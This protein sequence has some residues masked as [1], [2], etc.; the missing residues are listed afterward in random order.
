MS[1]STAILTDIAKMFQ[2]LN[3]DVKAMRKSLDSIDS[4]NVRRVGDGLETVSKQSKKA[5]S[6]IKGFA[7]KC[8]KM[9]GALSAIAAVQLGS[10]FT[11]MAGGILNMG[12]A[13]VQAAAQMRQYEIAFQTMLKSA[14]AGTQMLRDLQQ[15]AAETPF[16]VPGVVSAGQQLMAFGFKAEEIIPMLTNLGDAASGL[17]LGTEGV[18]RLAYALGQMQTSGKLNA[19]DMMQLTSAG[20][21][22]WDMLAQAAGK[23]V[24]EMKDLCSKGAIDSKAAVQTIVAGMNEQFGGMMAKTSDEV[25]GLLANIEETAGNTSAA[26]GKYLT[27]AFNIKGILK[28][29]SDRLGEF[30]QKMQTATE[31]GKSMGDVIKECVPAPVIAVIGAFAAVLVVVSVAAVATLGAVL[32][33]SAGIVAAGAAIGA[34]IALIITYWDDLANAVKAAVQGILDTVVIIGTAVTEVILGVVRWILDTIGD[35]WADITGDHNN[36]FNDFA[37]MLGDAMDA[38]EDFARK[39]IEWFNK[40]FAAKQRATA[41]ESSADDGHGG[42]G[43]SYGDDSSAEKPKKRPV[44]PKRPLII[45]SR[46]T[47]V[48]RTSGSRENLALKAL[49]DENRINQERRKI[50]NEYVRLKL[51]KEKDLFEAQNAIAKKYGTDAQKYQIQL[52][53]IEFNKKQELQEEE[54]AY[55][56][57]ML[58]AENALKEAQLRGASQKELEMLREKLALLNK[59]HQYTIDNINQTAAANANSAQTD[60]YNKEAEWQARHDTSST[61][62]KWSMDA[63]RD[64]ETGKAKAD[65]ATT[66]EEK[67]RLMNEALQKYDEEQQKINTISKIQQTSNQLAKDFSGAITDWITGA[68]SFGDAMKSILKQLIAQLIQAA[69]YATIVAACTGGGGG[70]AARWSK[71]FGKGLATGGS[72]DGPGTGTS[73]SVPAMLSNGE[74]VLNAQAVDRLGVP[75]L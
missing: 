61:V 52:K 69:I 17:G 3:S 16:D 43:G 50:E 36:W 48:G 34:A 47:N 15:F 26:V 31:Q 25:A 72:V 18:S 29:V 62:D 33:L 73:D 71:A 54:L 67:V 57:Q 22:A 35:M 6:G 63:E 44:I 56:E 64:F 58:A 23:T 74:Y 7:D 1:K 9:T 30:Q 8:N 39:A 53:E 51:K 32:G 68:Q 27:E 28:D 40:V 65:K 11:G 59:T 60:Y 41:T 12:I 2:Q 14:E 46:D 42:A 20:I 5:T 38:V 37:D 10:V 24:A 13:S 66:Y 49:Q 75:F 45:P 55:T 70:F 19:Q 21:S 4:K